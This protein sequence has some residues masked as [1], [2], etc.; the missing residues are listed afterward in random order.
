MS[1][2]YAGLPPKQ[3]HCGS[4]S[5]QSCSGRAKQA[6]RAHRKRQACCSSSSSSSASFLGAYML[7]GGLTPDED[8]NRGSGREK[9]P[10]VLAA[11]DTRE[12]RAWVERE[13]VG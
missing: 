1:S 8:L 2:S 3:R 9:H 12:L 6:A 11:V 4:K 13:S 5:A 10:S 7:D